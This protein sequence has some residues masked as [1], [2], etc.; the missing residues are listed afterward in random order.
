MVLNSLK[1][2][3]P[4]TG[5]GFPKPFQKL[6]TVIN[7]HTDLSED[8]VKLLWK[9][10]ELSEG[11]HKGQKRRSGEP[12]FTH[13]LE[14]GTIL[15]K[16]QLDTDAIISGLLHDI[17]EDTNVTKEKITQEFGED[18][19]NLVEGVTKLSG[20]K[21]NS[22]LQKQAEN[23]MKMFLSVAR[24]IRVIIIKFADR[25]HNMRTLSHLPLI[26][27]RRTAIETRD[28]YAPLAH[29]LGMWKLKAE[30]E[31]LVLETMEPAI[32]K[33]LEK[34]VKSSKKE[35]QK[36]I[37]EFTDPIQKEL[38]SFDIKSKIFGRSKHFTSIYGKMVKH[39][40][41]FSEIFDHLAI[42][43]IVKKVEECY[44]VLG[45]VHQIY[46]P[47]QERFKDFIATP[48][49][50]GY[51]SIHTTVFGRG[52]KM[53]EVQ[54][55]TKA[56]DETAEIGVAAH[57][58]Y[59]EEASAKS[60]DKGINKHVN[61]LRE[62]VEA[63]QNED[64]NPDEFLNLLKIDLFEEEIFVFT[65][66]GDV[67][68]L[69]AESTPIDFAF[70]VHSQVGFHCIGAKVNGK[71]VPLNTEL[72]N[73][74]TIEVI[75]SESQTPSYAWLKF[76]QT[77]KAKTHIKKWVKKQQTEQSVILGKEM[78]EK[79]LRRLKN[80]KLIDTIIENPNITGFNHVNMVFTSLAS[81]KLTIREV[82]NKYLPPENEIES[83][84]HEQDEETLTSRFLRK[85]RGISKGV[86]IDGI[87]NAMIGF[88]K[89]CNPI[90]GDQIVGYITRGRGVTIHRGNCKNLPV[91]STEDRLLNVE[92]NVGKNESFIVR[93]KMTGEDRKHLLKDIT[94]T[95]SHWNINL[96]SVDIGT[97]EGVATG[98]FILQ[99]RDTKQLDRITNKLKLV[100]GVIDLERM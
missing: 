82:I 52:G 69:K 46:T 48:K 58:A 2:V 32:F 93:L 33:D 95:I 11:A 7:D 66:R 75:T 49:S 43:I 34:K 45:I 26:K 85:A 27:Q 6:L 29:R 19:A 41:Q 54:I 73:G 64:K 3:L 89:C 72:K 67:V 16:W 44:A 87:S 5:N 86:V 17:I 23:F 60:L 14:V 61:W 62:L 78:L 13:C 91:S 15:A 63:L 90:P 84:D 31:D 30:L 94:E 76:A 100:K 83:V 8:S 37:D 38:D 39:G 81:G 9:A 88:G 57:W 10:Y 56:M 50:N 25:L 65:P 35:L 55:R 28:V 40:K 20:I 79:A 51:Q 74:D 24:D 1:K 22:R 70:Q 99:V 96:A 80:P 71:I 12:Y 92:W 97:N 77:A 18:I 53:F 21:F 98:I 68:Q 47:I 4:S 42:R 36:Y 59:K